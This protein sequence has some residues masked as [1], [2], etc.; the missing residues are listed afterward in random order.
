MNHYKKKEKSDRKDSENSANNIKPFF[1]FK[2]HKYIPKFTTQGS[3]QKITIFKEEKK[4]QIFEEPKPMS[5]QKK[6]MKKQLT[7]KIPEKNKSLEFEMNVILKK[8][9]L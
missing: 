8:K 4:E 3:D 1:H 2:K 9:N 7:I 5:P 6:P